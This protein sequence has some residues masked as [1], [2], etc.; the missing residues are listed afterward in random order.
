M[1]SSLVMK[2]DDPMAFSKA[3]AKESQTANWKELRMA[4]MMVL[5]MAFQTAFWM[6]Q[7]M[8]D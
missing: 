3:R 2:T 6:V 5:M 4:N 1:V 8:A 7:M